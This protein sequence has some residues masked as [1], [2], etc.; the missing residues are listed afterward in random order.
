MENVTTLKELEI[1]R[2]I[3]KSFENR[4]IALKHY[5]EEAIEFINEG[6]NEGFYLEVLAL[7][8]RSYRGTLAESVSDTQYEFLNQ[9][10]RSYEFL[11]N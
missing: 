6:Y 3:V 11:M 5:V 8:M 1:K 2:N 4:P 7:M 10:S 9:N